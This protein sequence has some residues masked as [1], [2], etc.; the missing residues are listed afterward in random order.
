MYIDEFVEYLKNERK[1]S[2]NTLEAYNRDISEFVAFE[3]S[4]GMNDIL[5]TSST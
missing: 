1:M 2:P 4:R 5:G 3:G